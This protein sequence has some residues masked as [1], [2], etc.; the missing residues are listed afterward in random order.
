MSTKELAGDQ[1]YYCH[2]YFEV[3]VLISHI[4]FRIKIKSMESIQ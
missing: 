4:L 3:L 2:V 1:S